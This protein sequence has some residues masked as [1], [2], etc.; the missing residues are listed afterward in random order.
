M[1]VNKGGINFTDEQ[2]N[3]WIEEYIVDPPTHILNGF[4]WSLWGIYDF[5][6][7]SN[8]EQIKNLFN[9]Y[10]Q[11]LI[12]NLKFYDTGYWSLY[13]QSGLKMPMLASPFYHRLHI[14]QLQIMAELT[15]FEV[16]SETAQKWLKYL[17]SKPK[18]YRALAGKSLF[19]LMHY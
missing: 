10:V 7:Y 18:F 6:L 4:I 11:T 3:N 2:G 14:I 13:E 19:K 17:H 9:G 16:F 12:Y 5:G 1:D 8:S 15:G